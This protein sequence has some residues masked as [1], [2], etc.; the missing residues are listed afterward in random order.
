M[1]N[2]HLIPILCFHCSPL[3]DFTQDPSWYPYDV[4]IMINNHWSWKIIILLEQ[5]YHLNLCGINLFRSFSE[6]R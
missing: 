4:P 1:F 2:M 3:S 6:I 5:T